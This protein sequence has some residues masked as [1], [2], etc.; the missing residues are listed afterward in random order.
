MTNLSPTS[1]C[2]EPNTQEAAG[3][4]ENDE[5]LA[6]GD[7]CEHRSA[8]YRLLARLYR[9]EVDPAFLDELKAT[10]FPADTGNAAIDAGYRTMATYLSGADSRTL[11]ELAVDYVRV[12]IGHGLDAYSAAYPYESV[13]TSPKRLMMQE[14]RDEVMAVY[15]AEG[16][17]RLSDWNEPE[18]HLALELEFMAVMAD[19]TARAARS[20]NEGEAERLLRV[21]RSFL[22]DHLAS[23]VPLLT[24]D[25]KGHAK[26]GLYRG[27]A[28][29]T[30][31]MLEV[32]E[33]FFDEVLEGGD[34]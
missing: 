29:L 1:P 19:R 34:R 21:Q 32:E 12:F 6:L 27:T 24:A 5:L 25:M 14:A 9:E 8:L 26:C 23:W 10:R 11:T 30:E 28:E 22:E 15:A 33:E 31:G 4:L 13:Y 16:L 2:S 17:A 20:G 3:A 18:D 7:V